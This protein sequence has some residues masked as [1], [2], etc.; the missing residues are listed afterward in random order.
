MKKIL[1][2]AF[3][4]C[5][6]GFSYSFFLPAIV[7]ENGRIVKIEA[8]ITHG[9]GSIF[10]KANGSIGGDTLLS[11]KK[12]SEC[13]SKFLGI[14]RS[15]YNF[16]INFKEGGDYAGPSGGAGFAIAFIASYLNKS[17]N[18]FT[19]TGAIDE[20]CNIGLVGGIFEKLNSS[21]N[22]KIILVPKTFDLNYFIASKVFKE[23]VVEV[24]NVSQ[25]FEYLFS[26]KK[27]IELSLFTNIT[28]PKNET[29]TKFQ[30]VAYQIYLK[31]N[32]TFSLLNYSFGLRNVLE[33]DLELIKRGYSYAGANDLFQ[34]I[35]YANTILAV[36]S[37]F[38]AD[39]VYSIASKVL[40]ECESIEEPNINVDNYEIVISGMQRKEWGEVKLMQILKKNIT[41]YDDA[42][43]ALMDVEAAKAWCENSLLFFN[44]SSKNKNFE[45]N[46][47]RIMKIAERELENASMI[48]AQ[49]PTEESQF[50]LTSAQEAYSK[51]KYAESII[52]SKWAIA[53]SQIPLNVS[54]AYAISVANLYG[55]MAKEY[56]LQAKLYNSSTFSLLSMLVGEG[57]FEIRTSF[58]EKQ[59]INNY[60]A[61]IFFFL[62]LI[63][64]LYH[65][66]SLKLKKEKEKG[67]IK[68]KGRKSRVKLRT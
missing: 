48:V 40:K 38:S 43:A 5:I 45:L 42:I 11:I 32:K 27:P 49:Y 25:A 1:F 15:K 44:V 67:K 61:P 68:A 55:G 26:N 19:I 59:N 13:A 9:N 39:D 53:F 10:V 3:A 2:F 22:F 60:L 47:S 17:F 20:N 41:N 8:N 31:A 30:N 57:F 51:G 36:N 7:G 29:P 65:L 34:K 21:R 33:E 4:L 58:V 63:T 54:Q 16:Y 50:Y 37:S 62:F 18:N 64:L 24:S 56:A 28:L 23:N 46:Q 66:Y 52:N 14:N 6:V 35:V 12:A